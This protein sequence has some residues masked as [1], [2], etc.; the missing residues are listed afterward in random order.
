[1]DGIAARER[2]EERNLEA[3]EDGTIDYSW[4]CTGTLVE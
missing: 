1:M 2:K 3:G 4:R